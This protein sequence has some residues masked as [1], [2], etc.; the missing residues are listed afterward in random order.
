MACSRAK[1]T[2]IFTF[3][4]VLKVVRPS[5]HCN[6]SFPW[7]LKLYFNFFSVAPQPNS[8]L[9]RLIVE[10]SRPH[11]IRH[12]RTPGRTPLNEWSARRRGRYLHNTQQTHE[13]NIHAPSGIQTRDPSK[14]T[15]ADL[16]LRPHGHR[17]RLF[18]IC[19]CACLIRGDTVFYTIMANV[20][21]F[22]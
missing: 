20:L 1:F 8:R 21:P 19:Y 5:S 12:T 13:T 4:C 17:D 2:F 18:F 7:L 14:R 3:Y 15:A 10:V 16:R 22:S 6:R 9:D 11:T